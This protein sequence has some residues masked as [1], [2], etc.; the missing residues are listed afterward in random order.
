EPVIIAYFISTKP[1]V[2]NHSRF[3]YSGFMPEVPIVGEQSFNLVL[4]L[5]QQYF[6]PSMKNNHPHF[7]Y[8]LLLKPPNCESTIVLNQT[9][10][11]SLPLLSVGYFA[12]IKYS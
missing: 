3:N 1:P 12:Q 6:V 2:Y 10:L 8:L 11:E 9:Q 4:E 7:Q 5:K